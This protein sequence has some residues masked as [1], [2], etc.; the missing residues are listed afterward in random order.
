MKPER[1]E[2][3]KFIKLCSM[4][5]YT[6]EDVVCGDVPFYRAVLNECYRL[7]IAGGT[8]IRADE[9]YG[10]VVRGREEAV[11]SIVFSGTF[12]RPV[13]VEIVDAYE[14]L[15]RLF[16]FFEE[17]GDL[18]FLAVIEPKEALLTKYLEDS[19]RRL[20]REDELHAADLPAFLKP[21]SPWVSNG[22]D[23]E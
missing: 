23:E 4:K 8:L 2:N 19:A 22:K 18:H 13:L 10:T 14:K 11:R 7:K 20:H 12:D 6:A 1:G 16:P 3:M 5:I 9:G 17:H 21:G 15:T